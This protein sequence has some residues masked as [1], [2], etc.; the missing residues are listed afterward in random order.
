M[1]K[2]SQDLKPCPLCGEEAWA[3]SESVTERMVHC[4]DCGCTAHISVWN[5]RKP[6]TDLLEALKAYISDCSNVEC[7][8]CIA[9]RRAITSAQGNGA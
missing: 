2:V 4:S 3:E 8:R 7:E 6:D 1:T 5:T 9:A